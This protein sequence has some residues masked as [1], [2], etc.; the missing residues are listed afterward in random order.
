MSA[1][2]GALRELLRRPGGVI[3][4]AVVVLLVASAALSLVWTPWPLLHTD[5]AE[6]WQG[7]SARHWL[8]TDQTGRDLF[9]WLLAGA[10][11]TVLVAV[12]ATLVAGLVGVSLAALGSLTPRGVREAVTVL[13]DLAI[14][15]PVLL[16]AML[17]AATIGGSLTVVVLAVGIGFGFSVARVTRPEIRRVQRSDYVLA[18]RAAGVGRV[19]M[20]VQHLVPNVGPTLVVQLSLAASVSVLAEAGLSYLGYGAPSGT[21][22]WGRLLS[23]TQGYIATQPLAVLWPGLTISIATLGLTLLGDALREALD[24]RLRRSRAASIPTEAAPGAA[25]DAAGADSSTPAPAT[26]SSTVVGEA[27]A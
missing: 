25:A 27:R 10:R 5:I 15:F 17:L 14:A 22:S 12:G 3:G 18:A 26:P 23:A 6:R 2:G 7:P 13:V 4:V 24:P 8:G 20:V 9:S 21:P 19:G 16:I 11:T 1:V